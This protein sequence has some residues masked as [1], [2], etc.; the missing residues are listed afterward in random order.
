MNGGIYMLIN[1]GEKIRKLRKRDGR[2]QEAL[3]GALGVTSQAVS[4]WEADSGYPDIE[5]IPSIANYFHI[6]IDELFGYNSERD[7]K[8]GKILADADA[9]INVQG[10]MTPCVKLLRDAI[11]LT[12]KGW[13]KYGARGK[14]TDGCDYAQN[15]TDYNSKNSYWLEALSLYE[16]VLSM[17]INADD[18]LAV[19]TVAVRLYVQWAYTI[20]AKS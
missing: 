15:D 11:S 6:T 3:A 7:K 12:Q 2:T 8:I 16:K 18:R 20:K 17:G 9:M 19:I 4:R 13:Q 5:T 14:T 10:D 1:L